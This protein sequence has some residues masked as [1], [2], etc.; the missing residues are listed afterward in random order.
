MNTS[1]R[2]EHYQRNVLHSLIQLVISSRHVLDKTP[3]QRLMRF[4]ASVRMRRLGLQTVL[5][6][7]KWL[8]LDNSELVKLGVQEALLVAVAGPLVW[9]PL[10][11][12]MGLDGPS[13]SRATCRSTFA[14]W[15]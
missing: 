15:R 13:R 8:Q 6:D 9:T 12:G 3:E 11:A 2:Q 14:A 10:L 5:Q 4:A 1:L 7:G